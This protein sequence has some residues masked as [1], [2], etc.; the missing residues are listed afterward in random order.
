MFGFQISPLFLIL[1]GLNG[2]SWIWI[3]W[4]MIFGITIWHLRK[5][6]NETVFELKMRHSRYVF[7]NLTADLVANIYAF[8]AKGKKQVSNSNIAQWKLPDAGFH[9]LNTDGSW[10]SVDKASGGGVLKKQDGSWFLG[11]SFKTSVA[12]RLFSIFQNTFLIKN[13]ENHQSIIARV[14]T[15]RLIWN[16]TREHHLR[17]CNVRCTINPSRLLTKCV[18]TWSIRHIHDQHI[19]IKHIISKDEYYIIIK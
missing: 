13:L 19:H 7:N 10:I 4:A 6:W 18:I 2:R 12:P 16:F 14:I 9:K 8:K 15:Y 5:S 3:E 1:N 11:Y 17:T